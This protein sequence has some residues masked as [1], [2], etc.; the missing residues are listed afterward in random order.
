[1]KHLLILS[2]FLSLSSVAQAMPSMGDK[3]KTMSGEEK[4]AKMDANSD[5]QVDA[6]EFKKA[7]PQMNDVVFGIIDTDGNK[8]ITLEEWMAFQTKHMQGMKEEDDKK[9][10]ANDM[11]M[12]MPPQD[13]K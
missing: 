6:P 5:K 10:P 11:L 2:L 8:I 13:K 7:H 1:M 9:K 3:A 4:Y 12:I